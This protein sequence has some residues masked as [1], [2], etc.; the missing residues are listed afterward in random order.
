MWQGYF[1]IENLALNDSQRAT[2][3]TELQAL[4]PGSHPSPACLCHWRTRLDGQAANWAQSGDKDRAYLAT[5]AEE[6]EGEP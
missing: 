3:V 5:N 1:G 2:L 6:W 4:G